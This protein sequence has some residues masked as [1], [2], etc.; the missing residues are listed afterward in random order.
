MS[1]YLFVEKVLDAAKKEMK[2]EV[3]N[4]MKLLGSAGKG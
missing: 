3:I 1:S 4:W 2:I